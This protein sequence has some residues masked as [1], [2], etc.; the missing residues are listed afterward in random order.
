MLPV[1]LPLAVGWLRWVVR[2]PPSWLLP[3]QRHRLVPWQG[4]QVW[5]FFLAARYIIPLSVA[6][7]LTFTHALS[8]VYGPEF[9]SRGE[10][11]DQSRLS[12]WATALAAPLSVALLLALMKLDGAHAYQAGITG[13]RLAQ[14]ILLGGLSFCVL[15][16]FIRGVN[17]ALALVWRM[18]V[19][20]PGEHPLTRLAQPEALPIDWV[21]GLTAAV[22]CAPILEELLFRGV[23]QPWC[24]RERHGGDIAVAV[25]LGLSAYSVSIPLYRATGLRSGLIA[26]APLLFAL[27]MLPVYAWLRARYR[28]ATVN[29]LFGVALMFGVAHSGVWP[30]PVALTLLGVGLGILYYRTQSLVPVVVT[31]A[32]FNGLSFVELL[33]RAF[34]HNKGE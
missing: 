12:I 9:L 3:P 13:H 31:H 23:L 26:A 17:S 11:L 25:A 30:S 29:G 28:S 18:W 16:P 24:S 27:A 4:S 10:E 33:L 2:R 22:I 6:A 15:T 21:I 5:A 34:G 8:R 7:L 1:S 32:L 19:T 14:D 20:V